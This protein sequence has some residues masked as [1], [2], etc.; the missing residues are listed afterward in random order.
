MV[1]PSL[2][3]IAALRETAASFPAVSQAMALM[4]GTSAEQILRL[5]AH[6]KQIA[7]MLEAMTEG[8]AAVTVLRQIPGI[9]TI[10]AASIHAEVVD[11]GRFAGENSLAC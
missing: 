5:K 7:A 9:A 4:I 10:T 6:R 8:C 1:P 3:L 11:I 2:K